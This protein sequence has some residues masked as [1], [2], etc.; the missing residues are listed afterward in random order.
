MFGTLVSPDPWLGMDMLFLRVAELLEKLAESPYELTETDKERLGRVHTV[1]CGVSR[2]Q[3][4]WE[5]SEISPSLSQDAEAARL[6]A[7]IPSIR[8][9]SIDERHEQ[10]FQDSSLCITCLVN[11][12]HPEWEHLK[13][14]AY[15]CHEIGTFLISRHAPTLADDDD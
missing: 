6:F 1:F 7:E 3:R 2:F 8:L 12:G 9:D 4:F 5:Q 14:A 11:G 15:M 13:S 10:R